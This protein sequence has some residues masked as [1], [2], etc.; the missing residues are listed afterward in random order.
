MIITSEACVTVARRIDHLFFATAVIIISTDV[1]QKPAVLF[2]DGNDARNVCRA[3][4]GLPHDRDG[5]CVAKPDFQDVYVGNHEA[6]GT[7]YVRFSF[8]GRGDF[9]NNGIVPLTT[10]Q[11]SDLADEIEKALQ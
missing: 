1:S 9:H 10:A 4:R 3:L 7:S 6:D 8:S 2:L 11:A 5:N